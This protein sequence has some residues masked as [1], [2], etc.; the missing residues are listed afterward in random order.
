MLILLNYHI[1]KVLLYSLYVFY[2][3]K[4]FCNFRSIINTDWF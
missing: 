2:F 4:P 3:I 1:P